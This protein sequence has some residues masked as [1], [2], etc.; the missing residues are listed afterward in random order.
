MGRTAGESKRGGDDDQ[1]QLRKKKSHGC[2]ISLSILAEPHASA[3]KQK[4]ERK[5]KE[6]LS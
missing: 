4:E 6:K 2:I 3:R 5:E 1:E